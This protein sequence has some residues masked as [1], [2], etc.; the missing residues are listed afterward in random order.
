MTDQPKIMENRDEVIHFHPSVLLL[1]TILS[2]YLC[3]HEVIAK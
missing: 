2:N 1:I 3:I